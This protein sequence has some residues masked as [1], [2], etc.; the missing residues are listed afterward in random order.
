MVFTCT[1]YTICTPL[2]DINFESLLPFSTVSIAQIQN[3]HEIKLLVNAM[4][5]PN[6][7]AQ[8]LQLSQNQTFHSHF[9]ISQTSN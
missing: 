8:F 9:P 6:F 1:T 3:E 7:K 2:S 4:V 5:Q